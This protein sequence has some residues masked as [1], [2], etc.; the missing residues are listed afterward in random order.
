[1][2]K[3]GKNYLKARERVEERDYTVSEAISLLKEIKTTR[4]D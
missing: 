3:R 2:P 4:F 1:M